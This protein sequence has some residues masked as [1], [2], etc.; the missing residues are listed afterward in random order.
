MFCTATA[1]IQS[2][3]HYDMASILLS[4]SPSL[5]FLSSCNPVSP[6]AA[7]AA[8]AISMLQQQKQPLR[9]AKPKLTCNSCRQ[10]ERKKRK[11]NEAHVGCAISLKCQLQQR[12][13]DGKQFSFFFYYFFLA[14]HVAQTISS[15]VCCTKLNEKHFPLCCSCV[16]KRQ[17]KRRQRHQ[18]KGEMGKSKCAN[19]VECRAQKFRVYTL[20]RRKYLVVF[21]TFCCTLFADQKYISLFFLCISFRF[22]LRQTLLATW[23]TNW[24]FLADKREDSGGGNGVEA[25]RVESNNGKRKL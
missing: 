8:V 18:G 9:Q 17:H 24:S 12:L 16:I 20:C 14:L 11:G 3:F 23:K 5:H 13:K 22:V 2:D 19:Y 7:A 25:W 15:C 10:L 1:I 6:S 4:L 21:A